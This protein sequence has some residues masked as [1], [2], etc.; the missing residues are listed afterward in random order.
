MLGFSEVAWV[1]LAKYDPTVDGSRKSNPLTRGA[2]GPHVR[3][4]PKEG[5]S[6][7]DPRD[8]R[9]SRVTLPPPT[10]RGECRLRFWR[11]V[12][13]QRG[14]KVQ[15]HVLDLHMHSSHFEAPIDLE[16]WHW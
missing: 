5:I 9:G 2:P 10:G 8:E 1:A 15:M 16:R 3:Q 6:S 12:R 14:A 4:L 7:D 13:R 11:L